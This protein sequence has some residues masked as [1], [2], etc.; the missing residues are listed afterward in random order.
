[1]VWFVNEGEDPSQRIGLQCRREEGAYVLTVMDP[2]G[3]ETRTTFDDEDAM[4]AETVRLHLELECRGG[5]ALSRT[6]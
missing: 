3:S 2:D 5:R 6:P 1:M 4:I